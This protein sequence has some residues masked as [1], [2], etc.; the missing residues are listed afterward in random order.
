[1]D[2]LQTEGFSS[3]FAHLK[4]KKARARIQ[5][6]IDRL[7]DGNLGDHH[8]VGDGVS[9]LRIDYGPGYR[10]YYAMQGSTAIIVLAG[11]DKASQSKD[12][13]IARLLAKQ[14]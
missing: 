3:W 10:V 8:F 11:G 2:V 7:E 14:L 5:M 1:M 6:R 13:K 12:I 4:D 9:E